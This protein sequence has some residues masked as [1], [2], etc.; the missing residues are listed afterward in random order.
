LVFRPIAVPA[1]DAE[2]G[3]DPAPNAKQAPADPEA[4]E[5]DSGIEG[6]LCVAITFLPVLVFTGLALR[7]MPRA[8]KGMTEG[9]ELTRRTL[10]LMEE[11]RE[12]QRAL[13]DELRS[14]RQEAREQHEEL[15][16]SLERLGSFRR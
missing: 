7:H 9:L 2:N 4:Q 6:W 10:E 14:L 13:L 5:E 15:T 3:G 1:Q 16:R 11:N 12:L 8:G